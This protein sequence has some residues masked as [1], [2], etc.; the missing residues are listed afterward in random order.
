MCPAY[1]QT[2]AHILGVSNL[3]SPLLKC[4]QNIFNF[5]F[6]FRLFQK[7]ENRKLP[8][9]EVMDKYTLEQKLLH[10]LIFFFCTAA[11]L[12]WG[13]TIC[14]GFVTVL[15]FAFKSTY[16]LSQPQKGVWFGVHLSVLVNKAY[17][18]ETN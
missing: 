8:F 16:D 6:I 3:S 12:I 11:L 2:H 14:L 13:K 1:V 7:A 4:M 5:S 10:L 18:T 17:M 15:S 9:F